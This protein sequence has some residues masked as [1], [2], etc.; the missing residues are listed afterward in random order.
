ML[1]AKRSRKVTAYRREGPGHRGAGHSRGG[2]GAGVV[3]VTNGGG[4]GGGRVDGRRCGVILGLLVFANRAIYS[5]SSANHPPF[6]TCAHT[7]VLILS[8]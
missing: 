2:Q 8:G 5:N 6:S 1:R 7:L 3:G 4:G